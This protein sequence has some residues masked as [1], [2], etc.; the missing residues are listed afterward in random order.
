MAQFQDFAL[1]LQVSGCSA[2]GSSFRVAVLKPRSM[3][4]GGRLQRERERER[5][6][7]HICVIGYIYV[8]THADTRCM[9]KLL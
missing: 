7:P 9:S 2:V 8:G 1:R 6:I 4:N 3:F 5:R